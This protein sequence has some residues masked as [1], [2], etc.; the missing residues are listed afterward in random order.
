MRSGTLRRT[1]CRAIAG[2]V[3][4]VLL[5][6]AAVAAPADTKRKISDA[7]R[8]LAALTEEITS[9]QARALAMQASMKVLAAKV[10]T[11]RRRYEAV[12][13][14]VALTRRLRAEVEDRYRAIRREIDAAAANAY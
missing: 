14:R 11:S 1:V 12:L 5:A 9:A 3:V 13:A 4:L 2:P 6:G 7:Q 10:G 8:R